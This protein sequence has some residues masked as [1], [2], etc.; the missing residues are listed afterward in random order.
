MLS[1]KEKEVFA[2][3]FFILFNLFLLSK[4]GVWN[5]RSFNEISPVLFASGGSGLNVRK[6]PST[7]SGIKFKLSPGRVLE[8][9]ENK[10]K[11]YRVRHFEDKREG[12]AHKVAMRKYLRLGYY[13]KPALGKSVL[14]LKWD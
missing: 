13:E 6:G 8:L 9:L 10:G 7:K 3:V 12:W 5:Q 2:L 4:V 11:W 14:E 1:S